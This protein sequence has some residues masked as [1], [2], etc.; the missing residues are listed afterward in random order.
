MI[1]TEKKFN[2]RLV[3]RNR[4]YLLYGIAVNIFSALMIW[5]ASV[6]IV[7]KILELNTDYTK[8]NTVVRQL[9]QKNQAL[10]NLQA[11]T[12]IAQQTLVNQ[13]LPSRKPVLELLTG[14]N[15]VAGQTGV[16][17][18]DFVISPGEIASDSTAVA[19]KKQAAKKGKTNT[20]YDTID[21]KLTAVGTFGQIQEFLRRVEQLA[22][23]TTV[24]D[25]DLSIGKRSGGVVQ[26]DDAVSAELVLN[27]HF[28]TQSLQTAISAPLPSLDQ[29]HQDLLAQLQTFIVPTFNQQQEVISSGVLDLFGISVGLPPEQNAQ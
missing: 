8:K 29:T 7:S 23:L 6:P 28:F 9:E 4:R 1:K 12:I 10:N 15:V 21:I 25:L 2:W 20:A 26:G 22:P 3:V 11:D 17:F 18:T 13:V 24:T 5:Q 19:S 16:S 14:I 27:T